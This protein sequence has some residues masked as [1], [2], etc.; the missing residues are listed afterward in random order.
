MAALKPMTKNQVLDHMAKKTK[1]TKKFAGEF[2]DE[3]IKLSYKEAKK[4]FVVPGLGKLVV[5]NRKARMGRNPA[6]GQTMQ[7]PAKRVLK[8]RIAKAAKDAVL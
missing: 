1:V 2:I 7:I 8:F 3:F 5:V 4:S 6:T